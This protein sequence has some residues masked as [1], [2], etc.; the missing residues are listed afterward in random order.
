MMEE[1][2]EA[3]REEH[4]PIEVI[5]LQKTDV[6]EV[7]SD[8]VQKIIEDDRNE[9]EQNNSD[10]I[11]NKSMETEID[12]KG[13]TKKVTRL[14]MINKDEFFDEL[15]ENRKDMSIIKRVGCYLESVFVEIFCELWI[16]N[17]IFKNLGY[18][19]LDSTFKT[20]RLMTHTEGRTFVE[21][22]MKVVNAYTQIIF[23][24]GEV[25][26]IVFK[27]ID[28]PKVMV[29]VHSLTI[30]T[31]GFIFTT[32]LI[33]MLLGVVKPQMESYKSILLHTISIPAT[34]VLRGLM[35]RFLTFILKDD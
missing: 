31:I 17:M 28:K 1:Q 27:E 32:I 34:I 6:E 9:T 5:Q 22:R 13:V 2:D 35:D 30:T 12:E 29:R 33:N 25:L 3:K 7:Q 26:A 8:T 24:K 4:T 21:I 11:S 20:T 23:E 10:T 16:L 19:I 18:F 15:R 14:K